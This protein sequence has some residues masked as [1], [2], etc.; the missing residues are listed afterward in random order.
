MIVKS[1][2]ACVK[3]PISFFSSSGHMHI[4][5]Q[6]IT[7]VPFLTFIF[8][9]RGN[10]SRFSSVLVGSQM[11][12][13]SPTSFWK[14]HAWWWGILERGAS[15]SS[16]RWEWGHEVG[17]F[18]Q[19]M[20][21]WPSVLW[22]HPVMRKN[23]IITTVKFRKGKMEPFGYEKQVT[24]FWV[25]H[26]SS[27]E[28]GDTVW[29]PLNKVSSLLFLQ[30]WRVFLWLSYLGLFCCCFF[31]SRNFWLC[32]FLENKYSFHTLSNLSANIDQENS[33]NFYLFFF[34]SSSRKS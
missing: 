30:V 16:T 28:Q 8:T 29:P 25:Y 6:Y 2:C 4:H 14:N 23:W 10:T 17:F 33:Y 31:S 24:L 3:A 9:D 21:L 18:P 11:V 27:L 19:K 20:P 5:L 32:G 22:V 15:T 1:V 26:L 34:F 7:T 12:G 13:K